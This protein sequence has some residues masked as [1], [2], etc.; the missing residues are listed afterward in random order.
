M[1]IEG[2]ALSEEKGQEKLKASVFMVQCCSFILLS[3]TIDFLSS[4]AE[5]FTSI[6]LSRTLALLSIGD[7]PSLLLCCF[8]YG[9]RYF[10]CA[11]VDTW[12]L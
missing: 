5:L 3:L 9:P 8:R 7:H 10:N 1:G 12:G 2:A 4:F 6:L 11:E